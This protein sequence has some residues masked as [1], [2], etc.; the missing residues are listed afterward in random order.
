MDVKSYLGIPF[1]DHGFGRDGC[2]CYGLVRLVYRHELGIELPHLGD[3]YSNA[4]TRLEVR[5]AVNRSMA[6]G[7]AVTVTDREPEP[8]DVLVFSRG[9]VDCHVGLWLEEGVMLH[10]IEG[11]DTCIE[12]F[13][14]LRWKRMFSRRLRHVSRVKD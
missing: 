8:L 13:D 1:K 4:L 11:F 3:E 10:V 9:A 7:W 14:T 6:D 5:K 2:D 12:R